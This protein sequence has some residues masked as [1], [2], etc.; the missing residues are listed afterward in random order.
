MECK[1]CFGSGTYEVGP[2]CS[3]PAS[4]CC[5]GCYETV[6]CEMCNGTGKVN[7]MKSPIDEI[8]EMWLKNDERNFN[9]WFVTNVNRLNKDLISLMKEAYYSGFQEELPFANFDDYLDG[10]K[11]TVETN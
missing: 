11:D 6:K 9:R 3:M 5:G 4:A 2:N 1:N 8:Y 10:I 7:E